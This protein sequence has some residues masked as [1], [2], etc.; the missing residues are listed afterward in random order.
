MKIEVT[1]EILSLVKKRDALRKKGLYKEA[2][3]LRIAINKKGYSIQDNGKTLV[4]KKKVLSNTNFL[5]IFGSGEI[6]HTGRRIHEYALSSIGKKEI[7]IAIITTPAGFQPNVKVVHEEIAQFFS[8]H[9]KNF[10]P[11]INIIY[12]NNR[13][14]ANNK[15]V[16]APIDVADYIFVGPGSPTYAVANLKNTLLMDKIEN[17]VT[18][19][20]S[21]AI[22][23]AAAIAFS[24]FC[25]PVYEIYKAGQELHWQKGLDFYA[26]FIKSL[27][28]IPHFNNKEGGW[29]T[30]T[31]YCYM[32]KERFK[33]ILTLLPKKEELWGI[34]E[35]TA[36]VININNKKLQVFGKGKLQKLKT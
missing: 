13:E 31:S 18:E 35:Q 19:G 14:L 10:H 36:I 15:K 29:K 5:I 26:G 17:K 1:P 7:T 9:L 22:A 23:S 21:L 32:G 8:N 28:V 6:S 27:T 3:K 30:D 24:K 20:A 16:V 2:D 4:F 11:K 34:D 25:L 33:Q 12:A